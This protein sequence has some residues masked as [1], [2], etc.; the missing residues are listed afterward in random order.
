MSRFVDD[1]RREWSRLGVPEAVSN[2]MAADLDADLAEAE[3]EGASPEEVLGNGVF[4][5]ASF[6]ASWAWARGVVPPNPHDTSRVRRPAWI[7]AVSALL[8][9]VAVV[10]GLVIIGHRSASAA[11][12][13]IVRGN[14]QI[15]APFLRPPAIRIGPHLPGRLIFVQGGGF[16]AVLGLALLVIG[17][18]G[19]GFT[20]WLWK[21]WSGFRR[22]GGLDDNVGL[23]SYL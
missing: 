15:P 5:A 17:L 8:S 4:D 11:A 14:V 13:A 20:V 1:C 16:D 3:A 10:A 9:L 12:T 19:L 23:P 2:E 7:V 6:A 18:V 21:P 22:R